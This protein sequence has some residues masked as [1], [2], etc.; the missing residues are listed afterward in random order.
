MQDVKYDVY[1][2]TPEES[3]LKCPKCSA[4]FCDFEKE[5]HVCKKY[6]HHG[7]CGLNQRRNIKPKDIGTDYFAFYCE[8]GAFMDVTKIRQCDGHKDE[9][10]RLIINLECT[11][12]G[13]IDA[14]KLHFG[15]TNTEDIMVEKCWHK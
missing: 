14:R 3:I 10:G 9:R 2:N 5:D 13:I 4:M 6:P 1:S 8:C 12:C 7:I 15:L 11:E